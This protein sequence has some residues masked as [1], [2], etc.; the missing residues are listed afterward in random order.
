MAVEALE[1][2]PAEEEPFAL[3]ASE[4]DEASHAEML[5]LYSESADS[6]RFAKAQQWKSVGATL[7]V[8]AGMITV[9]RVTQ[10]DILLIK[11]VAFLSFM[12]AAAAIYTLVLY[13]VWQNTEREKLREISKAF[14]NL[15]IKIRT[16]KSSRE[17]NVHRYTLL[18]FMIFSILIG[19]AILIM[20]LQGLY[21]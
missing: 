17:A 5:M 19:N 14:S 7:L 15:F 4:L 20:N 21:Q 12:V 10:S 3:E 13:Q 8:F 9:A 11:T 1:Y 16:I 6:I 2:E 18:I